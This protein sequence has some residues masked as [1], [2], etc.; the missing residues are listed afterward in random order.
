MTTT[1]RMRFFTAGEVRVKVC[2]ITT[3]EDAEQAVAAGADA[4]GIN[5]FEGSKRH[6]KLDDALGWVKNIPIARIAVV[7]NASSG[8]IQK[9]SASGIFDA[10]QFHGDESPEECSRSPVSWIRAVRVKS[11]E[12]LESALDYATPWLLLDAYSPQAYGGTGHLLDWEDARAFID[13][14]QDRRVILAGGLT[15]G[16]VAAAVRAVQPFAVDVASGVEVAGNPRRKDPV[17]MRDF[18]EAVRK[19]G[20]AS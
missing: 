13:R 6:V 16:N 3:S 18:I 17:L 14:V 20:A 1:D 7:V 8:F 19:A 12:T 11:L 2:G 10:I 4:I 9:I 5:L 15:S